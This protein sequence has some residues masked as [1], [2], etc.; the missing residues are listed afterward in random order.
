MSRRV[1]P[2]TDTIQDI[3][4]MIG[5]IAATNLS[6][7][8]K[9]RLLEYNDKWGYFEVTKNHSK[10]KGLNWGKYNDSAGQIIEIPT[11]MLRSLT[12]LTI[13]DKISDWVDALGLSEWTITTE[14]I[15]EK[16]V[17]YEEGV[18][19]SDQYFVGI[20]MDRVKKKACIYHDRP[21]NDDY[22]VHELLHVKYPDW[23]EDQVNVATEK[24]LR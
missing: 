9:A 17:V 18:P 21:L 1:T 14:A 19:E 11:Q 20:Q 13:H 16:S 10:R 5:E 24:L 8:F 23:S 6:P 4:T 2:R 12:W 7:T 15:D 22:V 3:D